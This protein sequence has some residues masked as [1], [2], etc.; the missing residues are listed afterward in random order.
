MALRNKMLFSLYSWQCIAY[1]YELLI[2]KRFNSMFWQP[3]LQ[4]KSPKMVWIWALPFL[5]LGCKHSLG[6]IDL[7]PMCPKRG[8][9]FQNQLRKPQPSKRQPQK[10][11]GRCTHNE[12]MLSETPGRLLG[13]CVLLLLLCICP[14]PTMSCLLLPSH[15]APRTRSSIHRSKGQDFLGWVLDQPLRLSCSS[16]FITKEFNTILVLSLKPQYVD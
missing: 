2:F 6:N 9:A 8:R 1:F 13:S 12:R 5:P 4:G 7:W 15:G 14:S 11:R 10:S 16:L 3:Q